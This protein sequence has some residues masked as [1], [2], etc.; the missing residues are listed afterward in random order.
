MQYD[1]AARSLCSAR[2]GSTVV[3]NPLATTR[4]LSLRRSM[5][6]CVTGPSLQCQGDGW[7]LGGPYTGRFSRSC[8]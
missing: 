5:F 3:S 1:A 2:L 8:T 6:R 4:R 7:L